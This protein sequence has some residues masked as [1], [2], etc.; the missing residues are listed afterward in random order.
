MPEEWHRNFVAVS[1]A[2]MRGSDVSS[3]I[4]WTHVKLWY[5][6]QSFGVRVSV[7]FSRGNSLII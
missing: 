7:Y 4:T 6:L 5:R 1:I 2:E 3:S